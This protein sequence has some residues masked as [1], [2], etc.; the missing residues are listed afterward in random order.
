MASLKDLIN[1]GLAELAEVV[2]LTA[3][4]KNR[5]ASGPVADLAA[6]GA[7]ELEALGL[8]QAMAR[9]VRAALDILQTIAAAIADHDLPANVAE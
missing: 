1:A 7:A 6:K 8:S 2:R 5:L 9:D 4:L 3:T